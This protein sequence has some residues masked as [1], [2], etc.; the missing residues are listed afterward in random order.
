M[1]INPFTAKVHVKTTK[2][3]EIWPL[4]VEYGGR[5]AYGP[6]GWEWFSLAY[7]PS[8]IYPVCQ[9]NC[10]VTPWAALYP[11]NGVPGALV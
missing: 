4:A 9:P 2:L 10:V 8:E 1:K 6:N 7:T 5:I 11:T 3:A